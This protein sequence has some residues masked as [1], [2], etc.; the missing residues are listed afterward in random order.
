MLG[1]LQQFSG[2][3]DI[4]AAVEARLFSLILTPAAVAASAVIREGG[5]GGTVV[6]TL[7]AAANGSAV[8]VQGPIVIRGPHLTLSGAGALF[9]VVK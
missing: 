5:S 2:T 6:L 1:R 8:V 4:A 9:S 7:N 3:G